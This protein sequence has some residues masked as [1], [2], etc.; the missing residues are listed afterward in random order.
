[1]SSGGQSPA[2]WD[3]KNA[4]AAHVAAPASDSTRVFRGRRRGPGPLPTAGGSLV[5]LPTSW[6][7]PPAQ[8]F[9]IGKVMDPEGLELEVERGGLPERMQQRVSS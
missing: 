2:S 6:S 5:L 8:G 4:S 1:M 7:S 3:A 9:Q